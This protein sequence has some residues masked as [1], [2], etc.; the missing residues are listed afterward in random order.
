MGRKRRAD[1]FDSFLVKW[2]CFGEASAAVIAGVFCQALFCVCSW[3]SRLQAFLCAL[4][5]FLENGKVV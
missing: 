2:K 1:G 4:D 5:V 3:A